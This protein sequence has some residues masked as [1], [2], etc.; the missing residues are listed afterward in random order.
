LPGTANRPAYLRIADDLRELIVTGEIAP[1]DK[2][3]SESQLQ[4]DYDVSRIV[5]RRA[6]DILEA[7]GLIV[8][9]HG[10]GSIVRSQ[11]PTEIRIIGD[12]YG[13]RP[14][15]SPFASAARSAGQTPEWEYQSRETTAT[16]VIAERLGI[17][18]G[19]RVMKTNYVF[20]ADSVPIMMSTSYEAL[21]LTG[22]TPIKHPEAGPAQ[23]V[24]AR[25]D[26]IGIHI[27]HVVEDVTARAARP[28]ERDRLQIPTGVPVLAVQRTYLA[29]ERAV[30]TADI[31]VSADRYVLR[32]RVPLPPHPQD[33]ETE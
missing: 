28:Q 17:R 23:G 6:A 12:F 16:K 32:Y 1:G 19:A 25:M 4:N 27:T 13:V 22:G 21:E 5:V 9:Q 14:T 10:R 11:R 18:V 29:D 7:E 15:S 26:S 30:E 8:K 2:I 33:L 31:V 24:I 3:P 20:Y